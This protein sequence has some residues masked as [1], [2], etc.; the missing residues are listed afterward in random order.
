MSILYMKFVRQYYNN[1]K[2]ILY[3]FLVINNHLIKKLKA[4]ENNFTMESVDR[5]DIMPKDE[6]QKHLGGVN[7]NLLPEF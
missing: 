6:L 5:K 2:V 4:D 7:V 1:V 3:S